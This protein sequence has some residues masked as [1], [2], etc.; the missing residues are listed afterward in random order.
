MAFDGYHVLVDLVDVPNL[1]ARATHWWQQKLVSWILDLPES[2]QIEEPVLGWLLP[3]YGLLSGAYRQMALIVMGVSCYSLLSERRLAPLAVVLALGLLMGWLVSPLSLGWKLWTDARLRRFVDRS[4]LGWLMCLWLIA[5]SVFFLFPLPRR[6]RALAWV[7]P[8][9][10]EPVYVPVAGRLIR[11]LAS[12]TAVQPGD[13]LL[14][15]EDPALE[16]RRQSLLVQREI[17]SKRLAATQVRRISES[18][19]S[20][21]LPQLEESL[22]GIEEQLTFVRGEISALTIRTPV[23]GWLLDPPPR[24]VRSDQSGSTR[25]LN[26]WTGSPLD[27]IN[28]GSTLARGDLACLVEKGQL[29]LELLVEH[30]DLGLVELGQR[31]QFRPRARATMALQGV[32]AEIGQAPLLELPPEMAASDAIP[33]HSLPGAAGTPRV[34]QFVVRVVFDQPTGPWRIGSSGW[35]TIETS[36][37][38]LGTQLSE[39]IRRNLGTP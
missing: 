31:V 18:D 30:S 23:S 1:S 38:S 19:L 26:G 24:P 14:Q 6:V 5:G 7:K 35:G 2:T 10:A 22:L 27:P 16:L 9:H 25:E 15:L 11:A 28:L 39:W 3:A 4:R 17:L 20:G 34:P 12:E 29:E 32:V 37:A 21:G 33:V 13:V 8:A 36:P